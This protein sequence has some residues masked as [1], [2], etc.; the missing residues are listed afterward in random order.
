[1][2]IGHYAVALAAKRAAPKASLGVLFAATQLPDLVWPVCVLTGLEHVAIAPGITAFNP[3]DFTSYPWSHSLLM[4]IAWGL[5]AGLGYFAWN[6]DRAGALAVTLLVVSHWVLDWI[7]HRADLPLWPGDRARVGLGLWYSVTGTL[8]IEC[9]LYLAGTVLYLRGTR[10]LDSVGRRA[11]PALLLVL[12]GFYVADRFGT[13]PP[14]STFLGWFALIGGLIP[15]IWAAW[16]DRH[17]TVQ[18]PGR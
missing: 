15:V 17:R 10:P 5:A 2:F 14:N 7:T 16:A 12:A 11:L 4:V 18:P 8:V 1:M 9:S 6:R 13:P 3:L